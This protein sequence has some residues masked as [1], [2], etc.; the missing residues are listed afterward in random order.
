[1]GDLRIVAADTRTAADLCAA[2]NG[3]FSDD[4]TGYVHIPQDP[5]VRQRHAVLEGRPLE[6]NPAS[7]RV[8]EKNG[9]QVVGHEMRPWRGGALMTLIKYSR[10][11]DP[12]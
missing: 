1:M 10:G 5:A 6:S 4:V 8:L 3:A 12:P 11:I 7:G 2:F 9:F